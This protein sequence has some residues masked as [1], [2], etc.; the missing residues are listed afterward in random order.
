MTVTP[1]EGQPASPH[2]PVS[3]LETE[4]LIL[5]A[6]GDDMKA[7]EELVRR[8][9]KLVYVSFYQLAPERTDIHDLTQ[10]ALLR[11]CRS[12]K[13]LRNPATFKYWLNR[14]VVN[15]FYDELRKK[16]RQLKTVSM[17]DSPFDDDDSGR[18]NTRD[19]PDDSS[20]P[21]QQ[22]L[23]SELDQRIKTAIEALPEQFR[24]II[25]LRELQGL[26]YEEIASITSTNIGTVKSRLAR[27]RLK[28]Q[29]DLKPYLRQEG[30]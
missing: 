18:A 4:D 16:S 24:T 28:L 17:D 21:D 19:V 8:N 10:E 13:S 7:L 25:V 23:Q 30:V 9:Q 27:A 29:Q 3:Q 15:L 1:K 12:I 5:R 6:Q 11:M 14:I 22:M 2:T 26:S 20:M